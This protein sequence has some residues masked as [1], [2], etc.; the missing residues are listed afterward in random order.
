VNDLGKL[1]VVAGL[2][3]AGVGVL[4]WSG[5]GRTWLGRLPGDFHFT[6]GNTSIYFPF[7]TCLLA[8]I[9]LTI[10]LWLLRKL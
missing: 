9:L 8:S 4:L 3:L 2:L 1:L 6:R 5:L 7:M 10:L